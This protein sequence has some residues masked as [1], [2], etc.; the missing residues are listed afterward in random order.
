VEKIEHRGAWLW[1]M[2]AIL[3]VLYSARFRRQRMPA[4]MQARK[5]AR[6]LIALPETFNVATYFVDRNVQEGRGQ[7]IAIE[8][9]DERVSYQQLLERTN[10]A[11]NALRKL[12]VRLEERVL[13]LLPDTPEFLYCF[14]GAIKIGAVAVPVSTSARP[15][16]YEHMLNDCRARVAVVSEGLLPQ[17]EMIPS[18]K[19]RHLREI[20]VVGERVSRHLCWCELM[21]G[22]SPD[23]NAEPTSKDDA[24]FWLYSSGSTGVSKGCVHL[25]HDMVVCSELYAKGILQM[26]ERDRCFSAARLFFAYGLGN[27]GYFPLS[28][29]ATTILSPGRPTPVT[30]YADIER[31]RPTLFF[32]VPT[33]YAALLAHRRDDGREFD[34]SSV[35]NAVSAG[36]GLPAPLFER[37]KERFGVEILDSM[38]STETLQMVIAN[39]PGDARPGSSGKIIPGYEAKIV[40]ESGNAVATNEI[41][42]LLIKGDSTCTGYWNQHEKTKETFV[43]H[44][45]RTGDK[46]YQDEDGYFWHAGRSDDLFKVNGRWLSPAEVESALIAHPAVREAAIIARDDEAGLAKPAAYVVVN[47]EFVPNQQLARDLQDWVAQKVGGYKRPRWIEFLTEIPKTAT[48]KLQRFKLRELRDQQARNASQPEASELPSTKR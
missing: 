48:G 30:L 37:F 7:N 34:L 14:F 39:R 11:G 33:N 17:L 12:G 40:D 15:G 27:A 18:E 43:G 1:K 24:A 5:V 3:P 21:D 25:H 28:C 31:Y 23:L 9:G 19:L 32:S 45:F 26:N 41:G 16:E 38:G 47:A 4:P 10:R 6:L 29:G 44:W 20:V 46:Y 13:L 22:A 8:C 2:A 36:E 35:R 42:D